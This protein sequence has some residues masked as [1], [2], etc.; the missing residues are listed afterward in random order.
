MSGQ[1]SPDPGLELLE[2]TVDSTMPL[3]EAVSEEA[4]TS[5]VDH[6]LRAEHAGGRWSLGFQFTSDPEMQRMH[7]EFMG[8]DSPTDIMTFPY[9]AEDWSEG[10]SPLG[11]DEA[12]GDIVISV[13]RARDHA[14]DADWDVADEQFFLVCHGMLHLVGWDDASDGDRAAMLDRQRT[15]M[16]S[17][18]STQ[19]S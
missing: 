15:L 7:L 17:W 19:P 16:G 2:V 12:G 9:E 4:I 5:L 6:V 18:R 14:E 8:L 13:D 1:G 10:G 11:V 3:P